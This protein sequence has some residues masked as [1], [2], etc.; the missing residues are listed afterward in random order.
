MF[1]TW[2]SCEEGKK[3]SA[4]NETG[5][6][7]RKSRKRIRAYT[8]FESLDQ[9]LQKASVLTFSIASFLIFSIASVPILPIA[10]FQFFPI[11]S[12]P[13]VSPVIILIFLIVSIMIFLV[14]VFRSFLLQLSNL[15]YCKYPDRSSLPFL[16]LHLL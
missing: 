16:S 1:D 5:R 14:Q 6:G 11:A 9:N 2:Y 12:F 4:Q 15:S 13:I 8:F 3:T 7:W 10:S